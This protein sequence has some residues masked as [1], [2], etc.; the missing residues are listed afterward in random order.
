M[1]CYF[2]PSIAKNIHE[3]LEFEA[4]NEVEKNLWKR[5]FMRFLK[6]LTVQQHK[7]LVLKSPTHGYRIKSLIGLFPDAR[8]VLIE[9]DPY[10]I[11]A[12]NL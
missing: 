4:M 5:K 7:P 12:S 10:D 1:V 3:L 8:F 2:S 6:M 11:F 9:R